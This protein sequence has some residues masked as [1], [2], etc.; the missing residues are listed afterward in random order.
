MKEILF[1]SYGCSV[2]ELCLSTFSSTVFRRPCR[3]DLIFSNL[4]S[5]GEGLSLLEDRR[6]LQVSHSSLRDRSFCRLRDRARREVDISSFVEHFRVEETSFFPSSS[7]TS[8]PED[9]FRTS[10]LIRR[11][12][13]VSASAYFLAL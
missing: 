7:L 3:G 10:R 12:F 13:E 6:Y 5:S 2:S 11:F 1:S 9:P 8:F 4:S